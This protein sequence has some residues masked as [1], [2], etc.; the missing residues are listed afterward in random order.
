MEK[1]NQMHGLTFRSSVHKPESRSGQIRS[2]HN[3]E[4]SAMNHEG[5]DMHGN[6]RAAPGDED[7]RES[8]ASEK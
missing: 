4:H 1:K 6:T 5:V 2:E 8:G 3:A 7:V